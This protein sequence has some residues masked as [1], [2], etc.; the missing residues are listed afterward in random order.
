M[1][2]IPSEHEACFGWA[3]VDFDV[4]AWPYDV[5]KTLLLSSLV[6]HIFRFTIF[7]V[8]L[9]VEVCVCMCVCV[10]LCVYICV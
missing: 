9:R 10:Y 8:D 7:Y 5:Q 1:F 6:T 4:W 3:V 2:T